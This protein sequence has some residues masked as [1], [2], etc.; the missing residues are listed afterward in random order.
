MN[1]MG[2]ELWIYHVKFIVSAKNERRQDKRNKGLCLDFTHR[3]F[4]A[5]CLNENFRVKRSLDFNQ[6]ELYNC[7]SE[8]NKNNSCARAPFDSLFNGRTL[9]TC[10]EVCFC[11]TRITSLNTSFLNETNEQ[12][13][14]CW[15]VGCSAL[16]APAYSVVT[17][18][19]IVHPVLALW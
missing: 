2:R 5:V 11:L 1:M 14:E 10:Q 4:G 3:E 8:G 7:H 15:L 6:E 17:R 13:S 18:T 9:S 19:L 16:L 12:P